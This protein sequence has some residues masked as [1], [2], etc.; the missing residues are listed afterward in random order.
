MKSF[1]PVLICLAL[2]LVAISA[3]AEESSLTYKFTSS[4]YATDHERNAIDV[5]LRANSGPHTMWIGQYDRGQ[6]FKQ[7]RTGYEYTANYD[8]G[9]V[10]P[11]LQMA[12]GGFVGRVFG[13]ANWQSG[14]LDCRFR[15]HQFA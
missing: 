14:L 7:T 10:V 15:S 5:N 9:Q 2:P 1:P 4:F 3:N 6:D 12:S 13:F 8:W 11:S